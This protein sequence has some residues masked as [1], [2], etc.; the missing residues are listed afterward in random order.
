MLHADLPPDPVRDSGFPTVEQLRRGILLNCIAHSFWLPANE[1]VFQM[2]W[3][4]NTYFEDGMQGE[5]LA[6]SFSRPGAVA[7]F[8]SSESARN[9]FPDGSPP[10]DQSHHFQG[11]PARLNQTRDR[12][13]AQ[14]YDFD[15]EI[16]NSAGA[17][18][19]AAMWAHGE[20]FMAAEPWGEVYDHS[21][22]VLRTYLLP[23]QEALQV[24]WLG[25]GFAES[26]KGAAWSL[27][28]RRVASPAP[29]IVVEPRE[30][31]AFV[32]LAGGDPD[33]AALAEELLAPVGITLGHFTDV[34]ST[35]PG[36]A[37]DG[38]D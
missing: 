32:E 10:Y 18:I 23:P 15:F 25:M 24:W 31:D 29:V 37:E 26:L 35:E 14:M 28:E 20:R 7:T 1:T 21:L 38:G 27:F 16:G 11:L 2:Y 30:W 19:T 22:G 12:A 17:V 36:A 34:P 5:H 3:T 9:P 8:F 13:L 6:V 33:K 4:G